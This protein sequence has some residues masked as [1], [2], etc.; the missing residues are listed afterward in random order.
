MLD[1]LLSNWEWRLVGCP[2]RLPYCVRY[3]GPGYVAVRAGRA[4]ALADVLAAFEVVD[5]A[6]LESVL[7]LGIEHLHVFGLGFESARA[8]GSHPSEFR[9]AQSEVDV[10]ASASPERVKAPDGRIQFRLSRYDRPPHFPLRYDGVEVAG[11]ALLVERYARAVRPHRQR[12]LHERDRID[13]PGKMPPPF[14]AG[15]HRRYNDAAEA[16]PHQVYSHAARRGG[17]L[18]QLPEELVPAGFAERARAVF[19]LPEGHL[20]QGG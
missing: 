11:P 19:H 20:P 8:E 17:P 13:L 7:A 14:G 5:L 15:Y 18:L 1:I 6:R 3:F 9:V 10:A 2:R 16:V 12:A 4:S